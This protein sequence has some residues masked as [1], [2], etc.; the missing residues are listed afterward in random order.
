[1]DNSHLRTIQMKRGVL[2]LECS[3]DLFLGQKAIGIPPQILP[4]PYYIPHPLNMEGSFSRSP[5]IK[6]ILTSHHTVDFFS[7]MEFIRPCRPETMW[8]FT[9]R[10]IWYSAGSHN[11]SKDN[12]TILVA[13]CDRCTQPLPLTKPAAL[14]YRLQRRLRSEL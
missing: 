11:Q 13:T 5:Y 6:P 8:I 10:L 1:M 7:W 3:I 9:D 4:K 14:W 12:D 2:C